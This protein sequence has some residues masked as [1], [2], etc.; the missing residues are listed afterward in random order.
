MS[1]QQNNFYKQEPL[2]LN[3]VYLIGVV[4]FLFY[5]YELV[6]NPISYISSEISELLSI[7]AYGLL[8][9]MSFRQYLYIKKIK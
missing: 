8:L 7:I 4:I 5:L 2:F 6:I 3:I 1:K 9:A